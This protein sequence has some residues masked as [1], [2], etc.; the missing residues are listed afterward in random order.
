MSDF[1]TNVLFL[2]YHFLRKGY[3]IP[4]LQEAALLA[5]QHSRTLLRAPIPGH[6]QSSS[7]DKVFL[8]TTY[9]WHDHSLRDIIFHNWEMLGR[10]PTTD[11]VY[12]KKLM[13][14]Y[15]RPKNL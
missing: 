7:D 14:G 13:C 15:R 3:P 9:H 10:H 2:T 12:Q 4:L 5:R 6:T 8:I 11:F 1:D